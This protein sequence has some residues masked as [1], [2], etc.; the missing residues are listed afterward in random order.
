MLRSSDTSPVSES[1]RARPAKGRSTPWRALSL[2]RG[3][4]PLGRLPHAGLRLLALED[5]PGLVD[6]ET[7]VRVRFARCVAKWRDQEIGAPHDTLT[8]TG[9]KCGAVPLRPPAI[10]AKPRKRYGLVLSYA[11]L[12]FQ[13]NYPRDLLLRPEVAWRSLPSPVIRMKGD[14]NIIFHINRM[15]SPVEPLYHVEAVCSIPFAAEIRV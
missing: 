13:H 4:Q 7:L 5:G 9:A 12:W 14:D 10:P 11:F 6:V 1:Q 3:G 15:F 2:G 8:V